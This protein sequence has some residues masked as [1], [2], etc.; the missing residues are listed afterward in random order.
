MTSRPPRRLVVSGRFPLGRI[1]REVP[2]VMD[3][4]AFLGRG[5]RIR[6][7][8][9]ARICRAHILPQKAGGRVVSNTHTP[10]PL[11]KLHCCCQLTQAG[12]GRSVHRAS[13]SAWVSCPSCF[14]FAGATSPPL[15]GRG[16]VADVGGTFHTWTS[17]CSVISW[18]GSMDKGVNLLL[19]CLYNEPQAA[20]TGGC[21]EDG[22]GGLST[23]ELPLLQQKQGPDRNPSLMCLELTVSAPLPPARLPLGWAG[24]RPAGLVSEGEVS[25]RQGILPV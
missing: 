10:L 20:P 5:G 22:V 12:P 21:G 16:R 2:S 23:W 25:V 13:I 8:P 4:S 19:P 24:V 3:R 11:L 18:L 15:S 1:C 9:L 17:G 14:P 7:S 6:L